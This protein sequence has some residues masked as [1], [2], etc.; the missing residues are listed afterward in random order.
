MEL[1][2]ADFLKMSNDLKLGYDND[3]LRDVEREALNKVN[4]EQN[5][6]RMQQLREDW[7]IKF[8]ILFLVSLNFLH[9]AAPD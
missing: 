9:W 2:D 6:K 3:E 1:E 8:K 7:F 4:R 5:K